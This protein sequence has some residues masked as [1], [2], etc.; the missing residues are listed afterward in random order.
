MIR[1]VVFRV[2][3]ALLSMFLL[4]TAVF[5]M[6]RATGDPTRKLVQEN[7]PPELRERIQHEFGLDQPLATQYRLYLGKLLRGDLGTS[8]HTRTPVSR[9]IID[10]IPNTLL[11]AIPALLLIIFVGVP[12]GV[13]SAYWQGGWVDRGARF[14]AALGQS[15]PSFVLALIL[16]L[17]FAVWNPILPA[18]GFGGLDHVIMPAIVMA[19][20]AIAGL[21]RLFRASMIEVLSTDY[22]TVHRMKGLPEWQVLW[23]HALR[24]A[25]TTALTF[26]GVVTAGLLTGSVIAETVF[27]WPGVG[28][29]M[30]EGV[31]R[32]DFPLVQGVMIFFSLA[33]VVMSTL[34][35]VLYTLLNPRLRT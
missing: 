2:L 5:F 15:T 12:L 4:V 28:R 19:V 13:Y 31:D 27:V 11:L 35:D 16:I 24:N 21:I 22:I 30:I 32:R 3:H 33:Y 18:G 23:K 1:T 20:P 9:L 26:M 14:L 34:V 29:L 25:G 8:F 10:R 7:A 6:V 17:L